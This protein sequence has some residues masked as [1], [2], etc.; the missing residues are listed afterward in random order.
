MT[1]HAVYRFDDESAI[2]VSDFRVTEKNNQ[3]DISA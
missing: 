1:I 2:F 3:A